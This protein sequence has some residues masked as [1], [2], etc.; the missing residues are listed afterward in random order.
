MNQHIPA[1]LIAAALSILGV[2]SDAA[3]ALTTTT[4]YVDAESGDDTDAGT[5]ALPF[6]TISRGLVAAASTSGDVE[7]RLRAGNYTQAHETSYTGGGYPLSVTDDVTLVADN[8]TPA[9][10]P[11]IG[12]DIDDGSV[13]QLFLVDASTTNRQDISFTRLYFVGEDSTGKDAPSAVRVVVGSEKRVNRAFMDECTI[14]RSEMNASGAS[15]RPAIA[16]ET[17][18]TASDLTSTFSISDT[19]IY[20]TER[21]GI[22]YTVGD[23][24][25][26]SAAPAYS[27]RDTEILL[28]G[29]DSAEFG[30]RFTVNSGEDGRFKFFIRN[31]LVDGS[32]STEDFD[33]GIDF[34]LVAGGGENPRI[35]AGTYVRDC[36]IR[37]CAK[38]GF[39]ISADGTGSGTPNLAFLDVSANLIIDCGGAAL[40][41]DFNAPASPDPTK[42]SYINAPL[43]NNIFVGC[44]YGVHYRDFD[45]NSTPQVDH[46]HNTI[47]DNDSFSYFFEGDIG[48]GGGGPHPDVIAN[49]IV[50]GNNGGGDQYDIN[51]DWSPDVDTDI[52]DSCWQL[53]FTSSPCDSD[54]TSDGNITCDPLFVS[55][56]TDDYHL[57]STS[58][59]VDAGD[60]S[61]ASLPAEDFDGDDR[62]IDGDG[63]NGDEPDIGADEYDPNA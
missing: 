31:L 36:E 63:T 49:S 29:G 62:E 15:G 52:T 16:I 44:E 9:N 40:E 20:A 6:K 3:T 26:G 21:G 59:C 55:P 48:T 25:D 58:P 7:V 33:Y 22:E 51:E 34:D 35:L 10:W 17:A 42:N 24:T 53:L 32:D 19:T 56:S 47:A 60:A 46:I 4:Y 13:E 43:F 27:I 38:S 57:L 1:C 11:R 61:L 37:G 5:S 45:E 54:P 12:G 18:T 14:E 23:T 2:R 28:E 41:L 50:Y 8:S 30:L 39:R